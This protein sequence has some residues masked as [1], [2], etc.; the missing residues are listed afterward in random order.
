MNLP[1]ALGHID[2]AA[3]AA[4]SKVSDWANTSPAQRL[5]LLDQIAR[6]VHR[7]AE[8]QV[9]VAC[10]AKGLD[11]DGPEA[12]EEWLGGPIAV[13]RNI[14]LLR[15]S[16][17]AIVAGKRPPLGQVWSR[18]D[19]R[20]VVRTH[21]VAPFDGMLLKG[22]QAEV[23]MEPGVSHEQ[24]V[25]EQAAAYFGSTE[26]T[27]CAVLGAGNVA[28]IGPMDVLHELFVRN[29]TC[30]LKMHPVNDY[31]GRYIE[32]AFAPLLEMEVLHIVYG[33]IAEGQRLIQHEAIG[34]VHITGGEAA[35]D[36][37]VWGTDSEERERRKAANDPLLQKD[38]T[39]ELGCVTPIV[40]A[41]GEW[42]DAELQWQAR[43]VASMVA[44]NASFNCNSA[45]LLVTSRGW[46][47]R[48]TFLAQ[49]RGALESIPARRAYYPGAQDRFDRFSAACG[50]VWT[51][52]GRDKRN[53]PWALASELDPASD[54]LPFREEAWCGFL[55]ETA[56][57][58]EGAEYLRAAASFCNERVWG[59][60]SC[61][62]IAPDPI[63]RSS[64]TSVA[65]D[66][67][68]EELRYGAI[69]IN[70]WPGLAYGLV[71]NPWGAYPGNSL[72]DVQSGIG[73]VH[74]ASMLSRAEKTVVRG[75]IVAKPSPPWIV[76]NANALKV[77]RKLCAFEAAGNPLK[78]PGLALAAVGM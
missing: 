48:E 73:S 34:A 16:L 46:T 39:S 52:P 63:Q 55:A 37:I 2:K 58:E 5:A 76:G 65:F 44:N 31:V 21:P 72:A 4:A 17:K 75:P 9:R 14:R 60:L 57:P 19:G 36:A 67:M 30:V 54:A 32:L 35:H 38:V 6:G 68:I 53:L 66:A 11:V 62:V 78:L 27:A 12:A 70:H 50:N 7:Y 43:N 45:K 51:G 64:E 8:D 22:V 47:Q 42:T 41:P 1:T 49:V 56:L 59:N 40:I 18:P 23:W 28:S 3:L 25:A 71:G 26:G 10:A 69:A 29:R 77:A 20:Q 24:L 61:G 33:D 13:L 15:H 74:N